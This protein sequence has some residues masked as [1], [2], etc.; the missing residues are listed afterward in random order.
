MNSS[1]PQPQNFAET[2]SHSEAMHTL[3]LFVAENFDLFVKYVQQCCDE[4]DK[5]QPTPIEVSRQFNRVHASVDLLVVMEMEDVASVSTE[6]IQITGETLLCATVVS[7]IYRASAAHAHAM[8]PSSVQVAQGSL[9]R[10]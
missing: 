5:P 9:Q 4:N 7:G 8:V 6:S 10:C 3:V 1:E 2:P